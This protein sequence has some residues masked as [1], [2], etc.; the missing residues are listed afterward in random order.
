MSHETEPHALVYRAKCATRALGQ[1]AGENNIS[2]HAMR[3]YDLQ[4]LLQMIE[5][6]LSE[7]L[8]AM[9]GDPD[10]IAIEVATLKPDAH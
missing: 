10:V 3:G 1:M 6:E 2:L 5:Q 7:A 8:E 4:C 9:G